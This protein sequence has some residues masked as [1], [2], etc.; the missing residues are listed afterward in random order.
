MALTIP[1][2]TQSTDDADISYE[3]DLF[4]EKLNS[5][6][7]GNEEASGPE[8]LQEMML[9]V[10]HKA[11]LQLNSR[12]SRENSGIDDISQRGRQRHVTFNPQD[13]VL[14]IENSQDRQVAPHI[15]LLQKSVPQ[16][17]ALKSSIRHSKISTENNRLAAPPR[18]TP[19]IKT[20]TATVPIETTSKSQPTKQAVVRTGDASLAP[21]GRMSFEEEAKALQDELAEMQRNLQDR[22][23]RY[24]KLNSFK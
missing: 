9:S 2:Q 15:S 13:D 7:S 20:T 11:E 6:V 23:Q 5:V 1:I 8:E 10:V 3:T 12:S 17:T 19:A 24:S 18:P 4:W 14:V 22:M 16:P 21:G